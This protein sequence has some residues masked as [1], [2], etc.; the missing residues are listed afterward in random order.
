MSDDRVIG[1][2]EKNCK[3]RLRVSLTTYEGHALADLRVFVEGDVPGVFDR[4]SRKGVTFRRALL[5]EVTRLLQEAQKDSVSE[6]GGADPSQGSSQAD[7]Q[8]ASGDDPFAGE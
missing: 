6:T 5:P 7:D 4:P 8:E 1:I 3:E 2:V